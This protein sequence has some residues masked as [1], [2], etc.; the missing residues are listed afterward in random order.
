MA[1]PPPRRRYSARAS[2]LDF[3]QQPPPARSRARRAL[4]ARCS[5]RRPGCSERVPHGVGVVAEE[6]GIDHERHKPQRRFY[7]RYDG[8]DGRHDSQGCLPCRWARHTV[9]SG[10]Q[11][12]AEGDARPRR[13]A[14]HSYGV[15]EAVAIRRQQHRHCHRPRQERDRRPL[16]RECRARKFSR[17]ARQDGPARRDP[18][19]H[20][21]DQGGLR[22]AGRAARPRPR[23]ARHERIW[24]ATSRSPS[25]SATT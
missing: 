10:H 14:G 9:P 1:R 3:R 5:G 7:L 24:W 6:R 19:D 4:R 22:A 2:A 23:R 17:A 13:Q 12:A 11:G 16:R 15:E 18:P 20:T 8:A 21:A 25:S